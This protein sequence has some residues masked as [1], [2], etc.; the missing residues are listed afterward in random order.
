M[1]K[2]PLVSII[3]PIYNSGAF[4][5]NTI[6]SVLSQTYQNI[7]V[8]CIDD[9]STDDSLSICKELEK[10]DSRII[11]LKTATNSGQIVA[12][13]LGLK[14]SNGDFFT[15]VDSDDTID[16][17]MIETLVDIATNQNAKLVISSFNVIYETK[18]ESNYSLVDSGFYKT[19]VF[20][21]FILTKLSWNILSCIGGKLYSSELLLDSDIKF[22]DKYKFNEDCGFSLTV[23]SVIDEVYFLNLA[24]YNY[25]I[26]P[27]NS[28]MSSYR[29]NMLETN[30]NVVRLLGSLFKK[31]NLLNE[32]YNE[33]YFM[34]YQVI[35]NSL[36]NELKFNNSNF[37]KVCIDV[38]NDEDFDN[39]YKNNLHTKLRHK[40]MLWSLK[41]K[42]F[43]LAKFILSFYLRRE[44]HVR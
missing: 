30:L 14:K 31:Y 20:L 4:I 38:H 33:Y 42:Q 1:N 6:E 44:S 28:T 3:I 7:E 41:T 15:F 40:I 13:N 39:I 36:V 23:L 18:K 8:I 21:N 9:C 25:L 37:K 43:W 10:K 35:F 34:M 2:S 24:F 29:E 27:K 11:V 22:L 5:E 16:G 17:R 26:R 32:K 12:R 19:D